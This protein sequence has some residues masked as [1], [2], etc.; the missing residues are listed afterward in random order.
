LPPI[1]PARRVP[2]G[3]RL[4]LLQVRVLRWTRRR[5]YR[6]WRLRQSER[7]EPGLMLARCA[8]RGRCALD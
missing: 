5:D 7:Y 2:R 8:C 6:A 1:R 3:V 4:W